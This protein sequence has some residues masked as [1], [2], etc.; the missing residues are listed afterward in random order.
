MLFLMRRRMANWM[1]RSISNI[2]WWHLLLF[3]LFHWHSAWILQ[4][5]LDPKKKTR[6]IAGTLLIARDIKENK[7]Y[8][9]FAR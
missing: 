6:A 3:V 7:I 1:Y 5:W 4:L 2:R 9:V 8:Q